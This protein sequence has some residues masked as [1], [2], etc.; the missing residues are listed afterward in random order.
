MGVM[1]VGAL[2]LTV[3][4]GWVTFELTR[5]PW[6]TG[7]AV[8]LAV[9][10]GWVTFALTHSPWLAGVAVVGGISAVVA[11]LLAILSRMSM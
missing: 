10:L 4:L 6:L 1:I 3:G 9:G 2:V 5:S 7:V 8:V 11:L